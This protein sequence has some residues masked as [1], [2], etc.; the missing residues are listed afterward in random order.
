LARR[1]QL[2][3]RIEDGAIKDIRFAVDILKTYQPWLLRRLKAGSTR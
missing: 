1:T 3:D 2:E